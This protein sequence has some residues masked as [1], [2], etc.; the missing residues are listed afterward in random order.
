MSEAIHQETEPKE[1]IEEFQDLI[2]I[3]APCQKT[4]PVGTDVP[5]Y[6][7]ADLGREI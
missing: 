6:V 4:C 1:P 3:P 2:W 7:G 5:S